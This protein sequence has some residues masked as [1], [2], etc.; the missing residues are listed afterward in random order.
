[1]ILLNLILFIVLI[2]LLWWLVTLIPLPH[3]FPTII[4][5]IFIILAILCIVS[6]VL[7]HP[8]LGVFV[9]KIF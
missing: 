1:M 2:G 5:V 6:V 7:G 9:P 4:R 8:V 3:P